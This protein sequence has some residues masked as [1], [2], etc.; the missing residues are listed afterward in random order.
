MRC[1]IAVAGLVIALFNEAPSPILQPVFP[2]SRHRLNRRRARSFAHCWR[3]NGWRLHAEA[4]N[5]D[6]AWRVLE[7]SQPYALKDAEYQGFAGTV[8]RQQKRP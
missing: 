5:W 4:R 8:L 2:T 3:Q 1:S 6:A 7:R